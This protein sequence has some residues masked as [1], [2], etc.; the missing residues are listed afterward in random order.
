MNFNFLSA[1]AVTIF[2]ISA[3]GCKKREDLG[4][5]SKS[6]AP[7]YSDCS[8][9]EE[10]LT[11]SNQ[12]SLT[13]PAE[14]KMVVEAHLAPDGITFGDNKFPTS[15]DDGMSKHLKASCEFLKKNFPQYEYGRNCQR[16]YNASYKT[17]W[18]SAEGGGE[19]GQGSSL[20]RPSQA[21]E[22]FYFNMYWTDS[23]KPLPGTKFIVW[24]QAET[25]AVVVAAGFE[26]GPS[27]IEFIAG[28]SPEVHFF[29][30]SDRNTK[31][32]IA[33]LVDQTISVGPITNCK[34]L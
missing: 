5:S 21:E 29:L 11:L 1:I 19:F 7:Q 32:R 18:C 31:L 2:V 17:E 6:V 28:L 14:G 3:W 23:S 12:G 8:Y 20:Q 10:V 16:V 9:Y 27:S 4:A 26:T 25:K 30:N 13:L 33:R 22:I 24:N 34:S 15:T